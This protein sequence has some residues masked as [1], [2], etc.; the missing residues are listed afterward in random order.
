MAKKCC[1]LYKGVVSAFGR[2]SNEE[3]FGGKGSFGKEIILY[4]KS[5]RATGRGNQA[6]EK[7]M[8][9]KEGEFGQRTPIWSPLNCLKGRLKKNSM[10]R[11]FRENQRG[12]RGKQRRL[13]GTFKS[14]ERKKQRERVVRVRR[15][16]EK[17][18]NGSSV[19]GEANGI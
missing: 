17:K 5:F 3:G 1:G 2:R 10:G 4:K 6:G 8:G 18:G 19:L 9:W 7:K 12:K 15:G 16:G 11:E 14:K 13:V